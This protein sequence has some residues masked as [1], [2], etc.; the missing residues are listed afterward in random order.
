MISKMAK[1]LKGINILKVATIPDIREAAGKVT[2]TPQHIVIGTPQR[3]VHMIRSEIIDVSHLRIF[4]LDDVDNMLSQG[5]KDKIAEIFSNLPKNAQT[6]MMSSPLP[7]E[8]IEI[9]H[10]IQNEPVRILVPRNEN[11]LD[12]MRQFYVAVENEEFKE[13]ALFGL[14]DSILF[15]QYVIFCNSRHK[16]DKIIEDL[17]S[18]GFR[19]SSVHKGMN[20]EERNRAFQDFRDRKN[21]VLLTTDEFVRCIHDVYAS[22]IVNFDLPMEKESYIHR[23]EVL[24]RF[25]KRGMVISLVTEEDGQ[26][27]KDIQE[28]Y[29]TKIEEMPANIIELL[30]LK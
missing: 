15:A 26:M 9:A 3:L 27:L 20:F 29:G 6:V 22:L 17:R 25:G 5:L 13:E 4:V 8:V 1:F 30:Q 7:S 12:D 24:S 23:F 28:V 11:I 18:I 14:F 2:E 16:V 21:R 10:Q 19:V